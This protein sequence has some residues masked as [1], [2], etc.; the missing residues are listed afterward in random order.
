MSALD[1]NGGAS[2]GGVEL[3]AAISNN[4]LAILREHIGR[5]SIKVKTYV[6]DEMV[7]V[8]MRGDGFTS[9]EEKILDIDE[10]DRVLA[11]RRDFQRRLAGRFADTITEL[12]ARS[13]VACLS[14]AQ[15]A[16]DIGVAVFLPRWVGRGRRR[17]RD[18]RTRMTVVSCRLLGRLAPV[19]PV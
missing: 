10:S 15:V 13:L 16:P 17:G 3:L 8:V 14:H 19:S 2:L 5:G 4:V 7:V 18:H 9:L 12:A 11:V 1:R 6:Y